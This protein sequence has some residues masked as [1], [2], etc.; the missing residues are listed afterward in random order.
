ML[1]HLKQKKV[2]EAYITNL[3]KYRY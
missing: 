1:D 2:V 3:N